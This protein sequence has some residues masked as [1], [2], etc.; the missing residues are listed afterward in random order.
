MRSGARP[1]AEA[2]A[3]AAEQ[4]AG[5]LPQGVATPGQHL[6]ELHGAHDTLVGHLWLAVH[7]REGARVGY[8]FDIELLAD[9]RGRGL[10]RAAMAAAEDAARDLDARSLRL[11]VFGHNTVARALY[12]RLGYDVRRAVFTRRPGPAVAHRPGDRTGDDWVLARPGQVNP[13]H[14]VWTAHRAGDRV[15]SA[16]LHWSRREDGLRVEG[17]D[18]RAGSAERSRLLEALA[19]LGSRRGA[20][21]VAVEVEEP[22]AGWA[23]ACRDAGYELTAELREK[24]LSSH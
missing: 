10:G 12:E 7:D 19:V 13:G 22:G 8:L 21:A 14:E 5:L 3:Y 6:W 18:L 20:V 15:A 23:D 16:C 24:P 4:L 2:D 11:N 9:A 1:R 17:H